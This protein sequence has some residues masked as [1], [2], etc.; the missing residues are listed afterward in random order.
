LPWPEGGELTQVVE[1]VERLPGRLVVDL[2]SAS[3]VTTLS[4]SLQGP[5]LTYRRA[6]IRLAKPMASTSSKVDFSQP[7]FAYAPLRRQ[8]SELDELRSELDL[9]RDTGRAR[10]V[11]M[12][13]RRR[14]GKSRLMQELCDRAQIRYCFY[15]A[16]RCPRPDALADFV[17]AVR[18][19]GLAAADAFEDASYDS[20]PAALR[21][22]AQGLTPSDPAV[23]VIDELPY[24]TELDPGFAADLL[25]AW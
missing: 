18:E 21:A 10:F 19:S 23:V 17:D 6:T 12:S 5:L 3:R 14:V 7:E 25:A 15:Q 11:W 2:A 20:W 4:T 16:P 1:A 8:A 24:L 9:V 13:G 22:A